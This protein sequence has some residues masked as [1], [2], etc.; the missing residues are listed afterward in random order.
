METIESRFLKIYDLAIGKVDKLEIELKQ[1]DVE[2]E[3]LKQ[4]EALP[5]EDKNVKQYSVSESGG[6]YFSVRV[7]GS[8]YYEDILKRNKKDL[9]FLKQ[10]LQDTTKFNKFL[11]MDSGNSDY[12]G[13]IT[14]N[15]YD[16]IIKYGGTIS[17]G[18]YSPSYNNKTPRMYWYEVNDQH[19]NFMNEK[20]AKAFV[21]AKVLSQIKSHIESE[22]KKAKA[23]ME[24]KNNGKT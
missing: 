16:L 7:T 15:R 1:K 13:K 5:F 18:C 2:L 3:L 9:D 24:A 22:T 21:K 11:K 19:N 8:Y 23:S 12:V 10:C 17:L 14:L 6:E 4:Q 20:K